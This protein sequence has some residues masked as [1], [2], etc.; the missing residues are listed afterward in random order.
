[1]HL[2]SHLGIVV[3]S[4]FFAL[5]PRFIDYHLSDESSSNGELPDLR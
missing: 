1:M 2:L 4:V 5:L 3:I